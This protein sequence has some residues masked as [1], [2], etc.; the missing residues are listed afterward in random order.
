MTNENQKNNEVIKNT[1]NDFLLEISKKLNKLK[2]SKFPDN[3]FFGVT[4]GFFIGADLFLSDQEY[5]K[6]KKKFGTN[7]AIKVQMIN[8]AKR[9]PGIGLLW[10]NKVNQITYEGRDIQRQINDL[11]ELY[12]LR[13]K[14][15]KTN[16][17]KEINKINE[18]IKNIE[19]K[20]KEDLKN[21]QNKMHSLKKSGQGGGGGLPHEAHSNAE[22]PSMAE[23]RLKHNP[24]GTHDNPSNESQHE[25]Y[26]RE[27]FGQPPAQDDLREEELKNK[28]LGI[29]GY[30]DLSMELLREKDVSGVIIPK[31]QAGDI[32]YDSV[33]TQVNYDPTKR[34][35]LSDGSTLRYGVPVSGND[36]GG[37]SKTPITSQPYNREDPYSTPNSQSIKQTLYSGVKNA[38]AGYLKGY[39]VN[40][41]MELVLGKKLSGKV[42]KYAGYY[43]NVSTVARTVAPAAW[44]A[45]KTAVLN[46]L[47]KTAIGKAVQGAVSGLLSSALGSAVAAIVPWIGVAMMIYSFFRLFK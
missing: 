33:T 35:V 16:N 17:P 39:L 43:S 31:G 26:V 20:I 22:T 23:D 28:Y 38:G 12:D 36:V 21:N 46:S 5:E 42:S 18:Q 4:K 10:T 15:S 45:A 30:V 19:N 1:Q 47:A 3:S 37:T 11:K 24:P 32:F 7:F 9:I 34:V 27:R 2:E 41:S 13:N 40:R 29:S 44:Q 14:L 25:Q 8:A 6:D